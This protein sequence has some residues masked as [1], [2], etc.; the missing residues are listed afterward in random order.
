M[1]NPPGSALP[2]LILDQFERRLPG[3][4]GGR[5]APGKVE[6]LDLDLVRLPGLEVLEDVGVRLVADDCHLIIL[7]L[8]IP[9][10]R[11]MLYKQHPYKQ[12]L[13]I[14]VKFCILL[15]KSKNK[16]HTKKRLV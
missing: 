16:Q 2:V 10:T 5:G 7:H 8:I 4:P 14:A 11:I 12:Q 6:G 3:D 13:V 9:S 1:C 15:L